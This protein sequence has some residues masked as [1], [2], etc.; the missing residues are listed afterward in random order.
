MTE[1]S[2][3]S[4]CSK[5]V[6]LSRRVDNSYPVI[7]YFNLKKENELIKEE[8]SKLFDLSSNIEIF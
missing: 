4:T 1:M 6:K 7:P 3:N 8:H 5:N 2:V